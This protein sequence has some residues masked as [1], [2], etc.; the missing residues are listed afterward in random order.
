M[1]A[2]LIFGAGFA[3]YAGVDDFHSLKVFP[4][5]SLLY[6]FSLV[7]FYPVFVVFKVVVNY[8][9]QKRALDYR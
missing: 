9:N 3:F 4:M 1:I 5:K 6:L 8:E 7:V 2:Y